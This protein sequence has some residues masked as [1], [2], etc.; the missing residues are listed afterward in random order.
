MEEAV[1][2]TYSKDKLAGVTWIGI[3]EKKWLICLLNGGVKIYNRKA[4]YHMSRGVILK[5]ILSTIM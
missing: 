4:N 5:N 2:L 1:K 3:S